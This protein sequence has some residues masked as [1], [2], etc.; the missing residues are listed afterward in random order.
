MK[1]VSAKGINH[2]KRQ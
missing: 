1:F 2:T